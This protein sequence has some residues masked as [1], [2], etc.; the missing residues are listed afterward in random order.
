M[1]DVTVTLT[2]TLALDG[3]YSFSIILHGGLSVGFEADKTL[4]LL[5]L[6]APDV[7]CWP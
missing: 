7:Q 3:A 2:V 6:G 5:L 1:P 4:V